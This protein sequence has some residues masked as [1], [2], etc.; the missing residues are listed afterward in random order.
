MLNA[1]AIE[2]FWSKVDKTPGH[3]PDGECWLWTAYRMPKGY[4]QWKPEAGVPALLAHRAS[5]LIAAGDEPGKWLVCHHCD[6]PPCVNP[7][8]LFLGTASD[9]TADMIRKGRGY[10]VG[11]VRGRKM[12]AHAVRRGASH[13]MSTVTEE[14]VLA[15]RAMASSQRI[16]KAEVARRFGVSCDVACRIIRRATWSHI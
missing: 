7:A 3:G 10:L 1:K 5:W 2:R 8:H 12:P 16:S 4:G 13:P 6:N 14:Q 11:G 9:N 15:I